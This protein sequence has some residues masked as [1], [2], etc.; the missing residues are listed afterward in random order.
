MSYKIVYG[1]VKQPVKKDM[2]VMI[3]AV[4]VA[5]LWVCFLFPK[6]RAQ[7]FPWTNEYA[8]EAF[9][10]FRNDLQA[11]TSFEDAFLAYCRDIVAYGMEAN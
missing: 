11:G 4:F 3:L 9:S 5:I 7:I 2:S 10:D 6:T 8:V 1:E